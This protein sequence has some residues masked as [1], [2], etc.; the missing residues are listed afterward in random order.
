MRDAEMAAVLERTK[1]K[2]EAK[3]PDD[4]IGKAVGYITVVIDGKKALNLLH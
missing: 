2:I 3:Y 1:Q 4:F